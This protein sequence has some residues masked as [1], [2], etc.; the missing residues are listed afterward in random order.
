M[1]DKFVPRKLQVDEEP[2]SVKEVNVTEV[3]VPK[4]YEIRDLNPGKLI[5]PGGRGYG[6]VKARYGA[7][8]ATDPDRHHRDKKASRFAVSPVVR[9][10][11]SIEQ[12]ERRVIE[13]KVRARIDAVTAE[14]KDRAYQEGFAAGRK[15]G[16]QQAYEEWKK[17][18]IDRMQ[19]ID[20]FLKAAE[21]A[22][23]D[24]YRANEEFLIQLIFLVARKVILRDLKE[25]KEYLARLV[26]SILERVGVRENIRVKI[27]RTDLENLELL[28]QNLENQLGKLSNFKV[29]IS[30]E[31]KLGGCVVET[32]LNEINASLS[33]QLGGVFEALTGRDQA[34]GTDH[35]S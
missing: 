5:E 24:I 18:G 13:E 30:D 31:V 8:A 27:N 11:L 25:D 14:V 9:N 3:P 12:E 4:K 21:E 6:A 29:E 33:R 16:H 22:K 28:Q 35:G 32:E 7:L 34:T 10:H 2:F 1:T 15:E 26:R 17:E 23:T 20:S 19:K